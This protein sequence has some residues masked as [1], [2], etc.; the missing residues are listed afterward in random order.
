MSYLI[1]KYFNTV[2]AKKGYYIARNMEEIIRRKRKISM[3]NDFVRQSSLELCAE[4]INKRKIEG[5]VAELG[6]YKGEFALLINKLFPERKLYLF[7]TF[8]GFSSKDVEIDKKNK[9]SS[10]D[11]DFSDT[12]VH[13][14]LNKMIKPENCIIKKGHFPE[15]AKGLEESFAFV[16]ID[17]D[18]Y[19]PIYHGLNYF[20]PRL[21][22]GG[23]II[24]HDFNNMR[25]NG[26][27]EALIKFV[28]ENKIAFFPLSDNF[29]SAVLMR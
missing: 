7:D 6:V 8:E 15:T 29:G 23:F 2:L 21:V 4:E 26:V 25:Y 12:S 16:S 18:L 24:V 3:V 13:H 1:K 11:Q 27:R 22:E 20:Y 5:N 9:Y 19:E 14:V 28:E 10:F 17:A